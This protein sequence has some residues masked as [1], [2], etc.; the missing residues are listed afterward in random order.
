MSLKPFFV[1]GVLA[2]LLQLA[3][4]VH[5]AAPIAEKLHDE[6]VAGE[7]EEYAT[8]AQVL[9]AAVAGGLWGVVLAFFAS[10][11]GI[12]A[13]TALCFVGFSL[14][15][16]LKWLPTPHG[17][18]Y[19]EPVEWREAVHGLYM[20]Y[21]GV[22]LWL[23]A[24]R[25]TAHWALAGAAALVAGFYAFPGFTLP[26]TYLPYVP[27]LKALQG[28]ALFSWAVYWATTAGVVNLLSPVKRVWR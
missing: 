5:F 23:I 14:L 7:V 16:L 21:N 9:A 13:G 12:A 20:L 1:A 15:P 8:W 27:E 26:Q 25:R 10:R 2:G 11:L 28:I 19:A 17:V 24:T 22:V 3:L 4:L 6:L 18:S